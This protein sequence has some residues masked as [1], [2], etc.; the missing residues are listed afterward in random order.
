[1][2]TLIIGC[3]R[4]FYKHLES[5]NALKKKIKIVGFCDR[6]LKKLKSLKKISYENKFG[7]IIANTKILHTKLK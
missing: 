6:D 3:G 4:I 2:N 7:L 5:I 1:M